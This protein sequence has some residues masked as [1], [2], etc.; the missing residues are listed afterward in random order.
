VNN[1]DADT[2][3]VAAGVV[4]SIVAL[5]EIYPAWKNS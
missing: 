3:M 5:L 1:I 2:L 4:L